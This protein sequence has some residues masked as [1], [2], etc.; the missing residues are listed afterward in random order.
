MNRRQV[1]P[2]AHERVADPND[3]VSYHAALLENNYIY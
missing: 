2:L 3:P 1:E